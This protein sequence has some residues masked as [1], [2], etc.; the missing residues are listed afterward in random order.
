[1]DLE[2][3]RGKRGVGGMRIGNNG[4]YLFIFYLLLLYFS[5][6]VLVYLQW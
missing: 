3:R 1:M 6:L 5:V 4:F 2:R